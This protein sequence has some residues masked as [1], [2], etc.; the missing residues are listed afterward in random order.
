MAVHP[1]CLA[2]D[3]TA[4][5]RLLEEG[6]VGGYRDRHPWYVAADLLEQ[7]RG[8]GQELCILLASG[9]PLRL[10]HWA[11]VTDIE[12]YHVASDRQTRVTLGR[13]GQ[14]SPL[15]EELESVTLAP[16]TWQLQRESQEG[17]RVRRIHLD[18][19]WLRPYAICE[20]PAFLFT[21]PATDAGPS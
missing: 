18:A 5:A 10:T 8:G 17:L 4:L 14:V 11:V 19:Q 15:F 16:S 1:L 13:S 3:G 21:Q 2:V 9:S 7:A 20:T 6:E 12:V